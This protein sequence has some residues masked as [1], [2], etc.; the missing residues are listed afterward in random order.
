VPLTDHDR[1]LLTDLLNGQSGAWR[2][3]VDRYTS[4]VVRVIQHTAH[5]HSLRLNAD[6]IEDLCADTMTE[7]LVRDMAALRDFRG[8]CSLSTY[9]GVIARRIVV[10]RLAEHRFSTAM[11]HVNAH[12]AAVDFAS[13][14]NNP[15]R[16][17]DHRDQ[18]ESLLSKLPQEPRQVAKWLFLD[19]LSYRQIAL[20]LGKPLNSIGPI[21]SRMR[22]LLLRSEDSPRAS[23]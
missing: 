10:R 17:L 4:L 2:L 12:R 11:G 7:L 5:S 16:N 1:K 18:V 19:E 14:E 9:L 20:R 21:V 3:F 23:R 6:D 8:R 13:A 22:S 15:G